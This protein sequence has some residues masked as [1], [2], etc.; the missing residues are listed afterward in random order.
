MVDTISDS[1]TIAVVGTGSIGRRHLEVLLSLGHSE[2]I[3]VSEHRRLDHLEIA[4]TRVAVSHR[5]SDTIDD[6]DAVIVAS[7][8]SLHLG[9]LRTAVEA[10]RHVLIEKPVATTSAGLDDLVTQASARGLVAGA[11]HQFR[12]EP[13]LMKIRDVV[14][15]GSLGTILAVEAHQGEHLADYHPD[16]DYRTGY[17]ARSDLG[18]G[19]LRTQIHHIDVLEWI[20][21]P[22][23]RVYAS[24]G[25]VT[26]L[27]IDVEDSASYLFRSD[28]GTPVYGHV[29]Y[30]QRPRTVS[31]VVVGTEGRIEWDHYGARLTHTP[32]VGDPIV[33]TWPYD[34]HAMFAS[35]MS[36][37]LDAIRG[38]APLRTTLRDGVRAVRLVE[39]I[40][41]SCALDRSVAVEQGPRDDG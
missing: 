40:E 28:A 11:G 21:G 7:P 27:E 33:T 30:R 34:R 37:F 20:F 31:L 6:V 3:A 14:R 23:V 2:L 24:G 36:D 13:G 4:G 32:S 29:D 41:R 19:V 8:T 25:H 22:L 17:A 39:A 15:E 1:P 12:Y 35:Q 18:G 5:L 10:G 26:D 9:H 38:G 16:E